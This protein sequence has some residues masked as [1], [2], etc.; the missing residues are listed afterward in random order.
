[1]D[2]W[3]ISIS[4]PNIFAWKE[5]GKWQKTLVRIASFWAK[6]CNYTLKNTKLSYGS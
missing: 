6:F 4:Y 2:V 1:M 5:T 3:H